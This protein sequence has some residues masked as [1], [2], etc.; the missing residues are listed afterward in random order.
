MSDVQLAKRIQSWRKQVGLSAVAFSQ[1]VE[2]VKA[3]R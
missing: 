1:L 2:A 3:V